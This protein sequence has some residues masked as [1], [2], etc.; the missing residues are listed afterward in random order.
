MREPPVVSAS[1]TARGQPT[2]HSSGPFL[3]RHVDD[4]LFRVVL[5]LNIQTSQGQISGIV[6]NSNG[7]L[8]GGKVTQP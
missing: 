7:Y 8:E 1:E 2:A 5:T 6:P 4:V 3:P